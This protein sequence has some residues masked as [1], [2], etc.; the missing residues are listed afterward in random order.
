MKCEL[1]GR[2]VKVYEKAYFGFDSVAEKIGVRKRKV[3]EPRKVLFLGTGRSGSKF[4]SRA[5]MNWGYSILHEATGE[6]GSSTHFFHTDWHWYPRW[7]WTKD[8]A[9]YGERLSDYHF[10][11]KVHV[12][13][14][15]L[16]CIPS[17]I[18]IFPT[19]EWEFGIETGLLPVECVGMNRLERAMLY[20]YEFNKRASKQCAVTIRLEDLDYSLPN[21]FGEIVG[22]KVTWTGKRVARNNATGFRKS[23]PTSYEQL[24]DVNKSLARSIRKMAKEFGYDV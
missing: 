13:R 12:I 8:M 11:N 9:H 14:N 10:E 2:E 19:L 20:Y 15:P 21:L 18:P 22:H 6:H 16:T 5:A 3:I 17:I 7:P 23:E 24:E 1:N 4:I